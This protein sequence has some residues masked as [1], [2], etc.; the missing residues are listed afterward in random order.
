MLLSASLPLKLRI[1]W[2][3]SFS[4][5]SSFCIICVCNHWRRKNQ[6]RC[7]KI[8]LMSHL[9]DAYDAFSSYWV[10]SSLIL[11][12]MKMYLMTSLT[13]MV[14]GPDSPPVCA[15]LHFFELSVHRVSISKSVGCVSSSK[16]VDCASGILKVGRIRE[17]IWIGEL[18]RL[19]KLIRLSGLI[20]PPEFFQLKNI[21]SFKFILKHVDPVRFC[22]AYGVTL[23]FLIAYGVN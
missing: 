10:S 8:G 12:L 11:S 20:R 18:I 23:L 7:S 15:F 17:L 22:L 3:D 6:N 4:G 13:M 9:S 1:I 16:P 19:S 2:L 21:H 5:V 14:L